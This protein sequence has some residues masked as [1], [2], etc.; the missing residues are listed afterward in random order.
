MYFVIIFLL[1]LL[2]LSSFSVGI[3]LHESPLCA[4]AEEVSQLDGLRFASAL[5]LQNSQMSDQFQT[6]SFSAEET[7]TLK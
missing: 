2:I 1:L 3:L 4:L 6:I 7:H 5:A